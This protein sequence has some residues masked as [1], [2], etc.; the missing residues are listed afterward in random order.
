MGQ[1]LATVQAV[2]EAAQAKSPFGLSGPYAV[3][4]NFGAIGLICFM[5][6][7]LQ[8]AALDQAKQDRVLFR[9]AVTELKHAID[10]QTEEIR[11]L[12]RK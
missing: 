5:F 8:S 11:T 3:I 9:D 6:W 12:T 2:G 10:R 1:E 7:Q 4:A